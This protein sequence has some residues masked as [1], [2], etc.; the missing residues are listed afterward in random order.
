VKE[1]TEI[2][3]GASNTEDLFNMAEQFAQSEEE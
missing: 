2:A 1:A 3:G